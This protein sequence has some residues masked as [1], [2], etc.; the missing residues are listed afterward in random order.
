MSKLSVTI[1]LLFLWLPSVSVACDQVAGGYESKDTMYV[2]CANLP[3][4]SNE[5]ASRLVH[6]VMGQY[7]GPQDEVLVYF[8]SSPNVVGKPESEMTSEE[9][10]GYYY[11]HSHKLVFWPN[12]KALKKVVEITWQ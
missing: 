1:T 12:S 4:L 9:L 8:V 7:K 10:V 2:V 5:N 6:S 11:T 3:S